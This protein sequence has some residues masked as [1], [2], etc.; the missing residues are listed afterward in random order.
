MKQ[1]EIK[2]LSL[3]ELQ[4]KRVELKKQLTSLKL[5]HEVTPLENPLRIRK[6]R[7]TIARIATAITEIERLDTATTA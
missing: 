7:R 5:A 2:E 1:A 3:E 4:E 6:V